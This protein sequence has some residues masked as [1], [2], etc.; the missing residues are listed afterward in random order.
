MLKRNVLLLGCILAFTGINA[1][2]PLVLSKAPQAE[3]N[4]WVDS[5]YNSMTAEQRVGQLIAQVFRT[6]DSEMAATKKEIKRV[7]DRYH[8]GWA[9]FSDGPAENHAKL[10]NYVNE[11]SD[12]PVLVGL[13]GEWGLSMRMPKTP[14]FPKN[15]MLGAIQDDRLLYEYGQEMARECKLVGVNANFAPTIDVNSDSRNPVIGTRSFGEDA[16]NVSGK[17]VAYSRGL[18]DAG[19]LSVSK[20][21]PGHGNT[22]ADSHKT[23]PVVDRSLASIQAIDLLPFRNYIDAGLGGVMVAHLNVPALHTGNVP[24]SLS[25]DVTTK[26][27]KDEMG[28]EGL[29]F[30]DALTMR[31]A[32]QGKSNGLAAFKAGADVLLEPYNLERSFQELL[33][34]YKKGGQQ[35][36]AIEKSCKK[37]LAYKYALGLSNY[38][39]VEINGLLD[40]INTREAELVMRKLYAAAMTVLKNDSSLL[41]VK[42]LDKKICAV[43]VGKNANDTKTFLNTCELYT[44]VEARHLTEVNAWVKANADAETVIVGV[45]DKSQSSQN[46]V[47]TLVNRIGGKKIILVFFVKPYD[48]SAYSRQIANCSAVVEAYEAQEYAQEYAAQVVFGGIA[49]TGRIPVTVDGVAEAGAGIDVMAS[50]L[51]YGMPEEVGLDARLVEQ[52]D[53]ITS[54]AVAEGAFPGCQVL[55]ARHGKVVVNKNYGYT[56]LQRRTAVDGETLYDLASVSKASGMLSG[57]MKAIDD[58]KLSLDGRLG[59]YIPELKNTEKGA[60]TIRDLLYHETGMPPSLNMYAIMTDSTSYEGALVVGRKAD[61]YSRFAGGAY[62]N[63]N[64]R[65]RSDITSPVKT[66]VYNCRIGEKLYVGKPTADTIMNIIYNIKLR[67]DRDYV[68]S[69]LNFCM[70]RQ[71]EEN[72]TGIRHDK[73]VYDNIFHRIGAYRTVYRPLES[74]DKNEIAA[75]ELDEYFRGGYVQGVVH[76]ETAAFTGGIQGNAGLFS[77]AN[78]LAKLCQ[79]WLNDGMY[80]GVQILSKE[81]VDTFTMSKSPNSYRGLGFD[82]PNVEYPEYSSICEQ[83]DPSVFGHT[84][85]TGTS[86]WVD[87]K[88]DLIYIFLCNRVCPSRKNPA[89]GEIGA[90]FKIFEMI[91]D[92]LARNEQK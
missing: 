77:N 68:Y 53:S 44:N 8:I 43:A 42:G 39:P 12:L 62:I 28:F 20:H 78:D 3:M 72:M 64:A 19:I 50:R 55:V 6:S 75:T 26:L 51:G 5:V 60:L 85:F 48:L 54:L 35:R 69:C 2:T 65:V 31:G 49:A 80:G 74:F 34:Y 71:A 36:A 46:I 17:G 13:D 41:P 61:G 15:M 92:S 18:E 81:T 23:L 16:L 25:A 70:L 10:A 47:S 33:S 32:R 21:F 88:N 29:V 79:M 22:I 7:V 83:A 84:G 30:T 67:D 38:K 4:A 82:K 90:R 11:I 76:D 59:D 40:R 66:D 9:Y 86:F 89:F 73:Y 1:K 56:D 91:Y 52:I 57:V 45:F 58:G 14:R 63:D 37:I 87:P 24:T 27:L